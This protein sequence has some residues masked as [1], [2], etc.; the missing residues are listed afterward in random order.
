LDASY[1][2]GDVIYADT[3]HNDDGFL[4]VESATYYNGHDA[5][6]IWLKFNLP[7]TAVKKAILSLYAIGGETLPTSTDVYFHNDNNWSEST[8]TYNNEPAHFTDLTSGQ[9]ATQVISE[10]N[11][12]YDFDVTNLV[13]AVGNSTITMVL[14]NTDIERNNGIVFTDETT[15]TP[16][17]LMLN[18][19]EVMNQE[20]NCTSDLSVNST[21]IF[22]DDYSSNVGWVE[23]GRAYINHINFSGVAK[24][25]HINGL[26]S[27]TNENHRVIKH[28]PVVLP[29]EWSLKT[30]YI[31]Q[32]DDIG[33][34]IVVA[35]SPSTDVIDPFDYFKSIVV[36]ETHDDTALLFG[37]K[38]IPITLNTKYYLL[39]EKTPDQAR[40]S[41]FSDP[42]RTI[43]IS[44]SPITLD[45]S[46]YA[47]NNLTYIQH[48]ILAQAGPAR[49][50]T[51]EID[52]TVIFTNMH[53]NQDE[54]S[55]H[56][57]T[58]NNT[59][60]TNSTTSTPTNSTTNTPTN[61][62]TNTPTNSTTS[63]PTNSTTTN[64]PPISTPEPSLTY[65]I[66]VTSDSSTPGCQENNECY[67][68][69]EIRIKIGDIIKW[70][71]SDSVAHTVTSGNPADGPDGE[72]GRSLWMTADTYSH[73]FTTEGQFN[74]YC[75]IHPWMT[76]TILV[77]DV[78]YEPRSPWDGVSGLE[79]SSLTVP[80]PV[81]IPEP[82]PEYD[83]SQPPIKVFTESTSYSEGNP[84][85]IY[86]EVR[87]SLRG[88]PVTLQVISANKTLVTL[89][90]VEVD[91]YKK[92]S[93]TLTNTEGP[94]WQSS[95][96][97]IVKAIYGTE[98]RTAETSFQ[99]TSYYEPVEPKQEVQAT[100]NIDINNDKVLV[101][102]KV[103][104]N[105]TILE[106]GP[107][108]QYIES[109]GKEG[110]I[111]T[112]S[113]TFEW[114][115]TDYKT[116]F[117]I[118]NFTK[119]PD[120]IL[121][122]LWSGS[123]TKGKV[124]VYNSATIIPY[125]NVSI[126]NFTESIDANSTALISNYT[127]S[128]VTETYTS[129][130]TP[131]SSSCTYCYIKP[132]ITN[133]TISMNSSA[134]SIENDINKE[135]VLTTVIDT[136]TVSKDDDAKP[137][138]ADNSEVPISSLITTPLFNEQELEKFQSLKQNNQTEQNIVLWS[139]KSIYE[140]GEKIRI[141]GI[142]PQT[143]KRTNISIQ[144]YSPSNFN[145]VNERLYVS[146]IG[147]F[148]IEFDTLDYL[149]F[150]NGAYV[151]KL[152]DSDSEKSEFTIKVIEP[153]ANNTLPQLDSVPIHA[154]STTDNAKSIKL[155]DENN[156]TQ[157]ETSISNEP[158]VYLNQVLGIIQN[159]VGNIFS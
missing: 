128:V 6:K 101:Y 145:I 92:Y 37:E 71:N 90:E 151:I 127:E 85:T 51:A 46:N 156:A 74:Y 115:G 69:S 15:K 107:T 39:L 84:I 86:G 143:M 2:S 42:Q 153:I 53:Q 59:S 94:L 4:A 125:D 137:V 114:N 30:E 26:G 82:I 89:Q 102:G 141:D 142:I 98:F 93:T 81:V 155:I 83:Y 75:T 24:L 5:R 70:F 7:V 113:D 34:S 77:G 133:S 40:L 13:N 63:T 1:N 104:L 119:V 61:S 95:G 9:H 148:K 154:S 3:V 31:L 117:W 80:E 134:N 91:K 73:E 149:W 54:P 49:I 78:D 124:L 55:C 48:G 157:E 18:Y 68:P 33:T 65:V 27:Y 152:V 109:E 147:M 60:T 11:R 29:S 8:L 132:V 103:N 158:I 131:S 130:N 112:L 87:D 35:L 150:E 135:I 123:G 121:F 140:D 126:L 41:V 116:F 76:G 129:T 57:S 120:D 58:D 100:M 64:P 21:I 62:T 111:S 32:Q 138:A 17:R 19:D 97:Y 159:F 79:S 56:V 88:F 52:N 14:S 66:L 96:T 72:F 106:N 25:D 118:S 44:N 10:L 99:F 136:K 146:D 22:S 47:Y 43:Q 139:D 12:Y 67:F 38:K 122:K 105:A 28:L 36:H 16:P 50:T 144:V 20:Q 45:I 110:I 23:T 108:I